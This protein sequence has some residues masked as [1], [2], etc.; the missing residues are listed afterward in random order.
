M[1]TLIR[2]T[3]LVLSTLLLYGCDSN[4]V[5]PDPNR[6][7]LNLNGLA[8]EIADAILYSNFF[9]YGPPVFSVDPRLQIAA[10]DI[11]VDGKQL[12]V[13]DF[14]Y[15]SLIVVGDASPRPKLTP[16]E[17]RY[18]HD[19]QGVMSVKDYVQIGA[20]FIVVSGETTP[21]LLADN[22]EFNYTYN[23]TN[24][25]ILVWSQ[26]GNSFTGDFLSVSG[27]VISL[28]MATFEGQPII[29]ETIIPEFFHLN[30]NYPNPF[31]SKTRISFALPE[32]S[33]FTLIINDYNGHEVF[34]VVGFAPAG[35][36][37]IDWDGTDKSGRQ[38][39][40]GVYYCRLTI[41]GE[42]Q[43]IKMLLQR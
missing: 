13:A 38:L 9:I 17:V 37:E 22:M 39:S 4:P 40:N 43:M 32:D 14:V 28:E 31:S 33:E 5:K 24:T 21:T 30:Q 26:D 12:T 2:T 10:S 1:A 25:R 3:I 23:G 34:R 35:V 20:A 11:N 36:T 6:G 41:R 16:V 42:T 27:N 15:L 8:F 29:F 18:T 7:D 19:N